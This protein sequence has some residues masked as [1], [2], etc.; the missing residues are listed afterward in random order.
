MAGERAMNFDESIDSAQEGLAD[1]VRVEQAAFR[2]AHPRK[3]GDWMPWAIDAAM[4]RTASDADRSAAMAVS[5][6]LR[7]T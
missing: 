4:A 1:Q 2:K 5:T 7:M 3:P 6:W